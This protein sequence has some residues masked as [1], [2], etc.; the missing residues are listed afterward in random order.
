MVELGVE[1]RGSNPWQVGL[2][3]VFMKNRI[4]N[5]VYSYLPGGDVH[6]I[7]VGQ[8]HKGYEVEQIYMDGVFIH[9]HCEQGISFVIKPLAYEA[10]YKFSPSA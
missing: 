3:G 5:Q 6:L 7:E 9:V 4:V 1:G 2:E 10:R 8:L